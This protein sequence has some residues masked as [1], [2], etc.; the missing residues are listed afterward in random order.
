M[1][2]YVDGTEE[3]KEVAMGTIADYIIDCKD[4][5]DI[6]TALHDIMN[7][8]LYT[9]EEQEIK[10]TKKKLLKFMNIPKLEEKAKK[11][12]LNLSRNEPISNETNKVYITLDIKTKLDLIYEIM[13]K[14][15]MVKSQTV[16]L[17]DNSNDYY[18]ILN[19]LTSTQELLKMIYQYAEWQPIH[20]QKKQQEEKN[21]LKLLVFNQ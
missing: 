14:F 15:E 6:E 12:I 11:A 19:Y 20:L 1:N 17:K 4:T 9:L 13:N 16:N 8:N 5:T 21:N 2:S 18:Y 10:D 7:L 3:M